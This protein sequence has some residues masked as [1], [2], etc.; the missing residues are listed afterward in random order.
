M[1]WRRLLRHLAAS[2]LMLRRAFPPPVLLAIEQAIAD[3]ERTHDGQICFA[4]EAA[5]PISPLLR[6]QSARERA[7]EVFSRLRVWDTERN[8]GILIYLLL[9]DHDVEIVADRGI[10]AQVTHAQWEAVCQEM[11]TA[12][13][14]GRFQDGALLAIQKI[15]DLLAAHFPAAERGNELPDRPVL[16]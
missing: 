6:G 3:S 4:L 5:L 15:R 10:S 14:A 12:F 9:A 11:E 13:R 2:D 1:K 16:L 8:N 7:I